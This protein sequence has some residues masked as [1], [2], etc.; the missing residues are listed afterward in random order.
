MKTEIKAAD[1]KTSSLSLANTQLFIY[2]RVPE[3]KH[4]LAWH[5]KNT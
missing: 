3:N 1:F 5:K 2:S 4:V